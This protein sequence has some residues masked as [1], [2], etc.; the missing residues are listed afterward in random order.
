MRI[1]LVYVTLILTAC[2]KPVIDFNGA[3]TA[4]P[5]YGGSA[6]GGHYSAA[7]QI[8]VSNVGALKKA[9][10]YRTGDFRLPTLDTLHAEPNV[11]LPLL[12][13]G[14][15]MTPLLV[16]GV[17]YGCSAFNKMFALNPQTGEEIWRVDPKVDISNE[18]MVNCRGV[19]SWQG[20]ANKQGICAHRIFMGSMDGRL[21]AVDGKNRQ[22]LS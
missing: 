4:W 1:A 19:S 6:G 18:V 20:T 5:S 10:E 2:S 9:W 12:A 16:D 7:T 17:L 21:L 13:S 14:W 11:E 22:S 3:V 15:Q 8:T